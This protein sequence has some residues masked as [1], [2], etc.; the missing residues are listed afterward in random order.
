M[1]ME[2]RRNRSSIEG[3]TFRDLVKDCAAEPQFVESFNRA[4]GAHLQA[5]ITALLDDCAPPQISD[6]EAMLLGCFIFFVHEQI[7]MRLQRAQ[8]R[9]VGWRKLPPSAAT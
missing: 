4:H 5:P 2:R 9:T 1:A 3:I 7:W 8:E 6:E